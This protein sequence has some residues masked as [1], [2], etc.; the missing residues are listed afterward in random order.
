MNLD[1]LDLLIPQPVPA[2]EVSP[3]WGTITQLSPLR[4][5][6]DGDDTALPVTPA[7]LVN[8]AQLTV[9]ARVWTIMN[10]RQLVVCGVWGGVAYPVLP[11]PEKVTKVA[12]AANFDTGLDVWTV[13]PWA[14]EIFD[15]ANAWT[16]SSNTK[17]ITPTGYTRVCLTLYTAWTASTTKPGRFTQIRKG[18]TTLVASNRTQLFE[19]AEHITTGWVATTAGDE[20]TALANSNGSGADLLGPSTWPGPCWLQ[21]EFRA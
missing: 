19:S 6:L 13:I 10:G 20:F 14:T 2:P 17:I 4:V 12:L 8:V 15:D 3:R 5:K 7:S 16:S 1:D 9:N 18:T 21:A 11:V